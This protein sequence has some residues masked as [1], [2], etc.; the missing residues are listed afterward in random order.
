MTLS[1]DTIADLPELHREQAA[2]ALGLVAK[3]AP[4]AR[5][6]ATGVKYQRPNFKPLLSNLPNC[7]A[8][9]GR[10]S[11]RRKLTRVGVP[12]WTGKNFR[13]EAGV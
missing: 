8:G 7:T 3:P 13:K 11:A 4:V 1:Y 12:A 2:Q 10:T 6:A 9:S 5:K